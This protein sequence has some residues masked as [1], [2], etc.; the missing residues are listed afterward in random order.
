M[1]NT[2]IA[3]AVFSLVASLIILS[4]ASGTS[5]AQPSQKVFKWRAQ[6]AVAPGSILYQSLERSFKSLKEATGGRLD[7][8]LA[9]V[10]SFVGPFEVLDALG[11]G[12]FEVGLSVPAYYAG[13]DPGFTVLS[14]LAGVWEN[15][16]QCNIWLDEYGGKQ[17]A[18]EMFDK[19]NVYWVGQLMTGAE[20]IMSNVALRKLEDFKGVKIRTPAGITA[21]LFTKLGATPVALPPGELYSALDT[22]VIDAA[23]WVTLGENWTMGLA[24]VTKYVLYPSFHSPMFVTD[25]EVSKKAWES[26]PPDLKAA[27]HM[28]A[29]E[30][31]AHYDWMSGALDIK[32][33]PKM[34]QKGLV[35][36]T[37]SAEDMKKA[38]EMS[39]EIVLNYKK[40]SPWSD[41]IITSIIDYLRLSGRIK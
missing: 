37:L 16:Q 25:I 18:R 20:P 1:K 8:T 24:E 32:T 35:H 9:G 39:L 23:E 13:K 2:K 21:E 34:I 17:L 40:K 15:T 26:L 41:K 29:Y 3:R 10:G 31:N 5:N 30:F 19:Y 11:K 38:K 28:A 22:K 4:V 6:A 7:I 14:T 33:L 12:I 36:T 27:F